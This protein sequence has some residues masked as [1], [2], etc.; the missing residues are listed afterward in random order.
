MV[1]PCS[2]SAS[3]P[4]VRS[5]RS[6]SLWPRLCE[7]RA[8]AT[9]WSSKTARVSCR[10]R[11]ISVLLPSSTLPAVMNRST[12]LSSTAGVGH[13]I[14][15]GR[16]T[17]EISFLLAPLH[18]DLGSL[19]VHARRAALGDRGQRGLGDDFGRRPGQ[20]FDGASAADVA[21]RAKAYRE[22]LRRL[23]FAQR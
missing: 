10:S 12:P 2:R 16:V 18:G 5:D 7:A 1:I 20:R 23:A 21:Y 4:S 8:S 3:S 17:S 11:P 22:L 13:S 9:S 6:M 19:I 15:S 14:S